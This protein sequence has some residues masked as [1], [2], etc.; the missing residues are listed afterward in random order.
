M[1]SGPAANW[2]TSASIPDVPANRLYR[3]VGVTNGA[4]LYNS[5]DIDRF[6]AK[7]NY[8]KFCCYCKDPSFE[9]LHGGIH[10]FVGGHMTYL[11][12]SPNDPVFF[13]H[14]TFIDFFWEQWRQRRQSPRQREHDYPPD[15]A[16]ACGSQY[17][18]NA[19]MRPFPIK[20]KVRSFISVF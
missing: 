5:E 11:A 15:G 18:A 16:R 1:T 2:A 17:N 12:S 19:S 4:A 13:A 9:I 6:L 10:D 3:Q 14:H 7:P 8:E 20:N